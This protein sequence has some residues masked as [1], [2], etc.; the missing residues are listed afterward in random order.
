MKNRILAAGSVLLG[1]V[2]A[3]APG[4]LAQS[5]LDEFD[6][7]ARRA[8]AVLDTRPSEAVELYRKAL[9]IRPA[10]ADG[11][12]YLGAGLYGSGRYGEARDAFGKG[13]QLAPGSGTGW[14]FLGLCEAELGAPER[15]LAA[16][17]KGEALGLQEN[18]GFETTVR[19]RAARI[20]LASSEF[21]EALA[22]L[23]P[24]MKYGASD[25][26]EIVEVMGQSALG[27]AGAAAELPP[28][29]RMV[30]QAAGLAAWASATRRAGEA[31][32]RYS[33]LLAEYPDEAGVHYANGLFLLESDQTLA[34]AE[35]ERELKTHPEH[36]PALVVDASLQTRRGAPELAV[37]R[38]K[39]A[40]RLV[41][42]NYAWLIHAELGRADLNLDQVDAAIA[43]VELA[44][45]LKPGNA[46]VHFLLS[47][48][49]RRA[50]RKEDAQRENAEFL[51][52]KS[53]QDPLAITGAQK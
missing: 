27:I 40:A 23:Q 4:A 53:Q 48:V 10:W 33:R 37:P 19:V 22:Q 28:A 12:L 17:S 51:R 50:G 2:L 18:R 6:D 8:E 39:E 44:L 26:P 9:A 32:A 7:L 41:P 46:Q 34:L 30:V 35:F 16:I 21:D 36:W 31:Q 29:R 38:L 13:L 45:R 5:S 43:E 47:Q 15:A 20:L 42:A 24:L 52:M 49:Y 3:A 1:V 14:A 11:W 25:P